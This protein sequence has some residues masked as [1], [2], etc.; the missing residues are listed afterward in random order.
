MVAHVDLK[1]SSLQQQQAVLEQSQ[2]ERRA[3]GACHN[4]IGVLASIRA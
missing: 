2:E 1:D 3:F 4:P